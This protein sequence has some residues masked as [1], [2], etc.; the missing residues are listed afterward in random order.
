[1]ESF[2]NIEYYLFCTIILAHHCQQSELPG[3]K[4]YLGMH[5]KSS[6]RCKL[7]RIEV[8]LYMLLPV[9]LE[10]P[11]FISLNHCKNRLS[12]NFIPSEI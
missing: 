3:G 7:L 10:L 1:M 2:L 4:R 5:L 8:M 6:T 9:I 12:D 11:K